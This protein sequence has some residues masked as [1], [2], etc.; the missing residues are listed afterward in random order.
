M[1]KNLFILTV[2]ASLVTGSA[3]A[4]S[5][6]AVSTS[7]NNFIARTM[8]FEENT[9]NVFGLG[10]IGQKNTSD[11]NMSPGA[12]PATWINRFNFLGQTGFHNP[13]IVDGINSA[14]V[15]AAYLYL[16]GETQY[17]TYNKNINKPA[18]G[19]FDAVNFILGKASSVKN[20]LQLLSETQ[21]VGNAISLNNPQSPGSFGVVPIHIVIRDKSGDSAVIEFINGKTEATHQLG[22]VL[23]NSPNIQWQNQHAS[24]YNYV[25]TNNTN[26]KFNGQY[27]NGSGFMGIPGDWTPPSRF[28]R[29][30]QVIRHFPNAHDDTQALSLTRQALAVVEVPLGTNPSPTIWESIANLSQGTYYFKPVLKVINSRTHTYAVDNNGLNSWQTYNLSKITKQTRLPEGWIDSI[31]KPHTD[32]KKVISLMQPTEGRLST[33]PAPK[34]KR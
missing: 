26:Q 31:I 30:T 28:S 20:A 7:Q 19:A 13:N 33:T 27:M 29:A 6:I 18:L 24:R 23:T 10:R 2:A 21:I 9:G 22:H 5:N 32:L 16:P 15:Y 17:P 11:T 14:G 3:L 34:F 1:K 12:K 25:S 8:D 4:C